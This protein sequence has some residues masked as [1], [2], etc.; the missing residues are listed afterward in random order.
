M[1][2]QGSI[3]DGGKFYSTNYSD[4]GDLKFKV[5]VEPEPESDV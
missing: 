3:Y 2:N 4:L 5:W 1:A